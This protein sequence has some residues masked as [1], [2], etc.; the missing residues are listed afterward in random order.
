MPNNSF[1]HLNLYGNTNDKRAYELFS[2]Q[3]EQNHELRLW[4]LELHRK[5]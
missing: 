5:L 4:Y 2:K 3:F 1:V